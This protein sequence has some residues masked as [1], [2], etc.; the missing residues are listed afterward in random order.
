[1]TTLPDPVVTDTAAP[2]GPAL[3][4]NNEYDRAIDRPHD[5]E[6][7]EAHEEETPTDSH[8]LANADHDEKG[9]AQI[10]HDETEVQD[11]GWGGDGFTKPSSVPNPLVGGLP[12]E[13]LW[14]L[15]RRFNKVICSAWY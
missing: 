14:T 6:V 12:N 9:A 4:P 15:V 10:D 7:V 11:L 8:A 13:E 2:I 1:M 3:P 5:V